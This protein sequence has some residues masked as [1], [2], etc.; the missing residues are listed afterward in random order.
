MLFCINSLV[1]GVPETAWGE[2]FVADVTPGWYVWLNVDD[3]A[4]PI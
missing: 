4:M 3:R 1:A 2:A